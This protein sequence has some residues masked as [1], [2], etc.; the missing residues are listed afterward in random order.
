MWTRREYLKGMLA[1]G[2]TF[3]LRFKTDTGDSGPTSGKPII[4]GVGMRGDRAAVV[5]SSHN[6][7][8]SARSPNKDAISP[9]WIARCSVCE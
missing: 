9:H 4:V 8:K 3:G 1:A 5:F 6:R 7:R 2:A